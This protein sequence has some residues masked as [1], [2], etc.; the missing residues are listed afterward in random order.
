MCDPVTAMAVLSVATA[1]TTA[2]GQYQSA[3]AQNRAAERT[4]Q[5]QQDE[6]VAQRDQEVGQRVAQSRRD[7]ATLQV[8]GGEAGIGGNSFEA[9]LRDSFGKES[10]DIAVVRKQGGFTHRAITNQMKASTATFS[11]LAAGLQIASAGASG[12]AAGKQMQSP[13]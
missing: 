13:K 3:N 9:L 2:Y 8:A 10:Q 11:P 4:A 6:Y 12:Y 1:A 7:R 5:Q